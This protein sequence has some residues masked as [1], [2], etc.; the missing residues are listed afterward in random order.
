MGI[1]EQS[2][3]GALASRQNQLPKAREQTDQGLRIT[4]MEMRRTLTRGTTSEITKR[5]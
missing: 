5:R 3:R 1:P 4:K 2:G